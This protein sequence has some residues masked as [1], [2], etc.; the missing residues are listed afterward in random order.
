MK[1]SDKNIMLSLFFLATASIA[2]IK[3]SKSKKYATKKVLSKKVKEEN[4]NN[5]IYINIDGLSYNLY[6]KANENP[7]TETKNINGLINKGVCFTNT[8]TG[9]PSIT[10]PMQQAIVSGAW[11]IDTGNC[12][13]YYDLDKDEVIQYGR[14]NKLENIAEAANRNDINFIGINSWYF[15]KAGR[16]IKKDNL[17]LESN[18]RNGYKGRFEL[19]KNVLKNGPAS[20]FIAIYLDDIDGVAHNS[21]RKTKA[22]HK[23][24][25]ES[26][27][28]IDSSMIMLLKNIDIEIGKVINIL[29]ERKVF[30]KT[31]FVI[32][33]DHGI[34]PFGADRE[35][36]D[37]TKKWAYSKMP[38]LLDIITR[39]G[40]KHR[41]KNFKVEMVNKKGEKAK[42]DSDAIV[43][44]AGLQVQLKF[45][46][47][48]SD[49]LL[50]D[51][52]ANIK[53][54]AYYG[55]HMNRE[56]LEIRGVPL[57][58]ADLLISPKPPYHFGHDFKRAYFAVSQHDSL[59]EKAQKV[60]T[61]ISGPVVKNIGYYDEETHN[62]DM[63]PT[64][65]RIL[66]FEGPKG[67]TTSAVDDVL[68]DEYKGPKLK[69]L[70]FK[71][72]VKRV[73]LDTETLLVETEANSEININRENVGNADYNGDFKIEKELKIGVNRFII[74]SVKDEKSTRR[75]VFVIRS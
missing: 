54:K 10:G 2:I 18:K 39:A 73:K 45:R 25:L 70:G 15:E 30:D 22:N 31:T 41:G 51:I 1:K 55:L 34:V 68:M 33:S 29:K 20:N 44:T 6:K 66:G 50:E 16:D 36:D 53:N 62:I 46:K 59:D 32:T 74:E 75:V 12:Y 71:E 24:R 40:K 14:E 28:D 60:F 61:M 49:E 8:K 67:A 43:T 4:K 9:I 57:K 47:E 65:A 35:E 11:P 27:S 56:E 17:Y 3:N 58:F 37:K 5:L 64:M 38:D 52:V 21:I 13:R 19:L 7:L 69:V 23:T 48:P 26:R 42:K 72:N 63:A